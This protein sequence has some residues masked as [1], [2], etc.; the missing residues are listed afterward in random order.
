VKL[1]SLLSKRGLFIGLVLIAV[2]ALILL[3]LRSRGLAYGTHEFWPAGWA[4]L[5]G[6]AI[7]VTL[8]VASDNAKEFLSYFVFAFAGGTIGW[9]VGILASPSTTEEAKIFG[10]YKTAIVGFLS[11]FAA[12]KISSLWDLLIK[13]SDNAAPKIFERAYVTRLLLF[14]GTFFLLAAQQ[15]VVRQAAS[16]QIWTSEKVQPASKLVSQTADALTVRPGASVTFSGAVNYPDINVDWS[17]AEAAPKLMDML[18][19]SDGVL[20]I[21]DESALAGLNQQEPIIVRAT[22]RWNRSKSSEVKVIVQRSTE[23]SPNPAAGRTEKQ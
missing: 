11:G 14:V 2:A 7:V 19:V 18:K 21:P 12:S 23:A 22:S 9:I 6:L 17:V 8:I 15:Y 5:F 4:V 13:S 10:E 20:P 16:G 1:D 3:G